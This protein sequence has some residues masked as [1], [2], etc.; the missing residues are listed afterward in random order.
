VR[1]KSIIAI[2]ALFLV[3]APALFSQS[4]E[5]GAII[6]K[7][8]DEEANP[9]PGVTLTLTSEK[10]MGARTGVSDGLGVFRFPALPPGVYVLK[11]ELQGFGTVINENIRLTTT[12]TLSVDVSMRP[13]TVQEQ[14]TVIAKTPTVDVKSTETASVTLGN[15]ILRNIPNSQ[16][17]ADIVNLAPGVNNDVAY[18]A[19]SGRGVSWQMDGVGVGDP[20]GGTSWVFLDYNIIEEAKV[21]GIGLP[22]E[23]GNFTGVIFNTVTKSGG[24][25]F[26]GHFE[27]DYQG[28]PA[29]EAA[30]LKGVF[31]GGSFWGTENNSDYVADWPGITSP[32]SALVDANA[33]L[34]GPIIKDK[35]WF[36]AGAQWYNSKDWPTGFPYAQDYKQPRFFLKLSSQLSAKTNGSAFVEY[37]NYNGTYRGAG[38]RIMPDATRDQIDPEYVLNLTLTHILSPKTFFDFKAAYFNGYYNLEPRTG[39]DV[40]MHYFL[41]D[42]PNIPG[43][44]SR[45]KFYNWGS[46]A[47]H[48]R[49]RFQANASLT[50]YV[51]NFIKGS[52]DFKFGVEFER[53]RVRDT[54]SY[55]GANHMRYY[56]YW[57]GGYYGN[58]SA[59]Q[60]EG[61]NI[62]DTMTRLEGF[63][64]DSWQVTSRLNVSIGVRASQ[65]WGATEGKPGTPYKTSR[66]APRAGFTFDILG[67]RSTVL[68]AHYGEFTDGVYSY[69]FDRLSPSFSP[70]IQLYWDPAG[71]NWYEDHRV[72]TGNYN[73]DPGIKQPFMRQ[74][75]VGLER[76]LFEDASFSV[77]YINRSY[78]N[79]IA[80]YNALATYEAVPYHISDDIPGVVNRDF[81]LY[82][83]TSGDAAD[84]RLTNLEKIKNLYTDSIGLTMNPYRKYWGLEFLFNKRFSNKWQFLA[85]YVYS[86][87]KG[88]V[89]NSST[90]DIGYGRGM[91]NPNLWVNNDGHVT[92]DPTHMIKVQA[93][94]IL[95]LDISVNAYWRGI[96]G[97]AWNQRYRTS[98]RAFDQGRVTFNTETAGSRHYPMATSLDMRL[99]KVF[100]LASKYRLGL[101]FDIFNVFNDN[102]INWWGDRIDYDWISDPT[103]APSTQ[104]HDLYGLVMPRRARVGIRLIF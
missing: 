75:T 102:T 52:H 95:P 56:D 44:Q 55:T 78:H 99:E 29:R 16:F 34:G 69:N 35:L 32:L 60:Y 42:N 38:A 54:F 49:S 80:A 84:W 59:Y 86:Q 15:E 50:H 70:W 8:T 104:G 41:N 10:L 88:T 4:R 2:A 89:N 57:G 26:S 83:L 81:T 25:E 5:T 31:P 92:N 98:S 77:T 14:V 7:V 66:I 94:Y 23:Y 97:D 24:N 1:A 100:T 74:F 68:K 22:A 93:T 13:A 27:V 47:E 19:G 51:E 43:D 82:N 96:T 79:F 53:S 101:I 36:F 65:L 64:Q 6:G 62:K 40:N 20:A 37:D 71:Q 48:P 11:A 103:Y 73:I 21:M 61:Y 17:S 3:L 46:W 58:Y 76:E 45:W 33:H 85:S 72:V 39:R 63:V 12:A 90:E 67:D 87:C 91:T 28:H 18:G 30:G 9:L